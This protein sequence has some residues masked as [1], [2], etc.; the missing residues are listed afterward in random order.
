MAAVKNLIHRYA[1]HSLAK[2][3]VAGD[4]VNTYI[5]EYL[6]GKITRLNK[7]NLVMTHG[8]N[9]ENN[10]YRNDGYRST[11][12]QHRGAPGNPFL[13]HQGAGPYKRKPYPPRQ[14]MAPFME[15]RTYVEREEMNL[16]RAI[17]KEIL[18]EEM[19]MM[20][21]VYPEEEAAYRMGGRGSRAGY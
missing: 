21:G 10:G 16:H 4:I 2:R 13:H 6:N 7:Q 12:H 5:Q 17:I 20:R 18:R 11:H 9:F 14:G 8:R 3:I 1:H 19:E 15:G